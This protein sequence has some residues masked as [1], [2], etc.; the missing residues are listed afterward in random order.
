MKKLLLLLLMSFNVL[1]VNGQI[2]KTDSLVSENLTI[3][4][5]ARISALLDNY[6]NCNLKDKTV[7]EKVDISNNIDS[8][9]KKNTENKVKT[10]S[11]ICRDHTKLSGYKIQIA[12]LKSMNESNEVVSYFRRRFPDLR[13]EKDVSLRPN[14]KVLVGS[15]FT[16]ESSRSDFNRIKK[17]FPNSI[18]VPY[19]IFCNESK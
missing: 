10:I 11:E 12:V 16:K 4:M 7:V 17:H 18:L 9:S 13:A 6:E 1:F 8:S 15:Y 5:D 14:Y 2:A 3:V 19:R